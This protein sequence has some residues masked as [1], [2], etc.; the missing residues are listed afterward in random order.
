[1]SL[2]T[3]LKVAPLVVSTLALALSW[4]GYQQSGRAEGLS[5]RTAAVAELVDGLHRAR[6]LARQADVEPVSAEQVIAVMVD[7]EDRAH[8]HRAVLPGHLRAVGREVRAAMGNCFGTP[9]WAGLDARLAHGEM[10]AFDRYWWDVTHSY[11]EYVDAVLQDWRTAPTSRRHTK[12][13][14]FHD[15][16]RE[17]D[18]AHFTPPA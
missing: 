12:L 13:T 1:M 6:R 16:R 15:W 14:G 9:A 7:F 10:A 17:E 4:R 2:D 5:V 18:S 11:L 8:R 3:L